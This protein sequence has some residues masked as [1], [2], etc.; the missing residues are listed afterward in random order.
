MYNPIVGNSG[1]FLRCF[2]K[3]IIRL[4]EVCILMHSLDYEENGYVD[5]DLVKVIKRNKV[6]IHLN[7]NPIDVLD[8]IMHESKAQKVGREMINK[9]KTLIER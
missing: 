9:L 8:T 2:E 7:G 1:R 3:Q 5:A 4:C 6:S